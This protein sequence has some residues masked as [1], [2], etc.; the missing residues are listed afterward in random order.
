MIFLIVTLTVIALLSLITSVLTLSATGHLHT[1]ANN[2]QAQIG[3]TC[4]EVQFQSRVTRKALLDVL[5]EKVLPAVGYKEPE[6]TELEQAM[7][8]LARGEE[9]TLNFAT[10]GRTND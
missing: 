8:A 3:A 4:S 5:T 2:L 6:P 1:K 7:Q 10:L 9:P